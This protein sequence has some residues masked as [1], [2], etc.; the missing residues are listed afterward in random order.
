MSEFENMK[1]GI[2]GFGLAGS[3]LSYYLFKNKFTQITVFDSFETNS[4]TKIAAG[5]Y[6]PITGKDRKFTWLV[7]EI[8]PIIEPF[9]RELEK[10]TNEKFLYPLPILMPFASL[11]EK[12]KW[13]TKEYSQPI[14][15]IK[16]VEN[17][18]IQN[19]ASLHIP[20]GYMLV[21]PAG[22]LHTERFL[23][24]TKNF[25]KENGIHF[26]HQDL[27]YS[28]LKK[29]NSKWHYKNYEFDKVI[30]CEGYKAINNPFFKFIGLK[31]VKGEILS[32]KI[33]NLS[34]DYI[35][36]KSMFIVPTTE[37]NI[38][39]CG[40]TYRHRWQDDVTPETLGM[41]DI[42]K[43]LKILYLGKFMLLDAKAGVR[44]SSVDRKP[45]LGEHPIEKNLYIFNGLGTKG[46]SLAPYFGKIMFD[47]V[48]NNV[49]PIA[50]VNVKRFCNS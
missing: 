4:A 28:L 32:V 35:Y 48:I 2:V 49:E 47:L 36:N 43:R 15:N 50:V 39:K 17:N 16:V 14:I 5:L 1:I 46:V 42:Q 26:T 19:I 23:N 13:Y 22:Y 45:I 21:N 12:E 40:S 37:K 25:F 29:N 33:Q 34:T 6:N 18:E 11:S 44:P 8:F 3:V 30:F 27:I 10:L 31:P 9:Y 41:D 7:D 20:Y 24:A 38:F